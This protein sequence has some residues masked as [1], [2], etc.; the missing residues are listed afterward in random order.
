MA[1]NDLL[2]HALDLSSRGQTAAAARIL[3]RLAKKGGADAD[4]HLGWLLEI[5]EDLD[6]PPETPEELYEVSARGGSP[7]GALRHALELD[8]PDSDAPPEAAHWYEVAREGLERQ[9][10]EGDAESLY[11]L[12]QI[13]S[14]G[15][16]VPEDD[17]RATAYLERA[18]ESGH[19]EAISTLGRW[20]WDLPERTNAQRRRAVELWRRAADGGRR[21]TQYGLGVA[22][23][24]D[25]DM[26]INLEESVR[27]YR[28][29]AENGDTEALYNLGTMYLDGEG[30]PK[31]EARG[32]ALIVRAARLGNLL[33]QF[34]L[35]R[36]YAQGYPGVVV[37]EEE[38]AYWKRQS[39]AQVPDADTP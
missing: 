26:P 10:A 35:T 2:T 12:W 19:L 30:V 24:T 11:Q 5:G 3:R 37:D 1:D 23:A 7:Y 8:A 16:G 34:Y 33:A 14:L 17:I 36:A 39:D 29:A 15:W 28:M 25:E 27:Y 18:A 13:Y 32:T 4:A 9:A 38:A 21:D 6:E 31:D 20:H 22:Y